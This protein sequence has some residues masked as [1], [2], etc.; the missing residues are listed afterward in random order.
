MDF[1]KDLAWRG[2]V[3][4]VTPGAEE[5]LAEGPVTAYIGFDPTAASLHVGHLL[6]VLALVRLQRAG[7]RPLAV[8]GGGTGMIGDPSGK[9]QERQLLATERLAENVAGLRRQLGRFLDFDDPQTGARMVDNADWLTTVSLMEFLRDIGKH[10]TVN[11]MVAKESVKR[12]LAQEEGISFT[13]F[14]YMLLQAYDFLMLH[15][16][17]GC[18]LQVGG[19]DQWGNITAGIDLVRKLRGERVHALVMPLV[20]DAQGRKFGK[21]EAGAVW[22]D[23]E[24]TSPYRFYQ[25]WLNVGD[26]EA[27]RYLRYFT[28]LAPERIE[29]I[30]REAATSPEQRG[31]Q[32]VLA[33][34]VT[35]LVHGPAAL[36]RALR[37]TDLLFGREVDELE[38]EDLLAGFGDAPSSEVPHAELAAGLPPA[39]LLA[40]TG[41]TASKGEARRL[42]ASGGVYLNNRRLDP[43]RPVTLDDAIETRLLLLRKGK[44][45]YHLVR[46]AG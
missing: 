39:D 31:V 16:R 18:I 41:V 13:E 4:E 3:E 26:E 15:D 23:P 30:E 27:R 8:V 35:R 24:L 7:H 36:A 34:E 28:F 5:A 12:R 46:V 17:H 44:K 14:S 22:L 38:A 2:L 21:T 42:L 6:P 9:S 1:L 10:F 37:V 45:S 25:F 32:R 40:R 11:Q 20:T 43:E 19:S 33:E 29:E